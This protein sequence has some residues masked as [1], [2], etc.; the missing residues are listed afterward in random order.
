MRSF[1]RDE[2]GGFEGRNNRDRDSR[3]FGRRSENSGG[4]RRFGDRDRNSEGFDRKPL[5]KY[6]VICDKCKKQCD[7]PFK[8]T[9]G[10]PV[11]CRECF[12]SSKPGSAGLS[13]D[14]VNLI[15]EKLDKIIQALNI[16]K[17]KK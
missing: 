10:K 4:R 2:Q 3:G 6:N 11:L 12:A 15:N 1:R 17:P 9:Q 5:E 16:D 14:Q 7:V 13:I 8:P